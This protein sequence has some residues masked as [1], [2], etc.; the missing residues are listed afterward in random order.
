MDSIDI[1]SING[2]CKAA[3]E[4]VEIVEQAIDYFPLDVW[5]EIRYLGELNLERDFNISIVGDS[6][7]ALLFEKLVKKMGTVIKEM[8]LDNLLLGITSD[9][10]V[11]MNYSFDKLTFRR[12]AYLVHDY[13]NARLGVV[14][15]FSVE[16]KVSCKV[17]AHGL[18]HSKGLHHH[19]RPADLMHPALLKLADL[20]VN[21]FCKTCLR[22]MEENSDS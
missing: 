16:D 12:T 11:C 9:P 14:S 18:G 6:L 1:V 2:G 3:L 13:V 20:Q 5:D 7:G 15:L 19:D 22:D 17:I 21:G 10:I 8:D 4:L